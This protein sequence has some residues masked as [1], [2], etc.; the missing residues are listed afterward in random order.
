MMPVLALILGCLSAQA[1]DGKPV[2]FKYLRPEGDKY[3][4]ESEITFTPGKLGSTYT[5]V[6]NRGADKD[7]VKMTLTLR[8]D[9]ENNI[10]S[11]ETVLTTAKSVKKATL[12][13]FKDH[14]RLKREGTMEIL[15]RLPAAPVITTAPDWS[16]IIQLVNRYDAKKGGKQ[17]FGGIWFHPFEKTQMPTFTIENS[18]TDKIVLKEKEVVTDKVTVKEKETNLRR[19]EIRLRSGGY[20]AWSDDE[21]RIVRFVP[22]GTGGY[23]VVLEGFE[24]AT[25][26]LK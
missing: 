18:G 1:P 13:L 2:P 24:E 5:S 14:A 4:V 16:D 11:A 10:Q 19:Y 15:N 21:G 6:T 9:A 7:S 12:T 23:P 20:R 26:E 22:L 8:F 25:R 3:V 17:E